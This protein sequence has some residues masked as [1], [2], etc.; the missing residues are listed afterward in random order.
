MFPP[1]AAPLLHETKQARKSRVAQGPGSQGGPVLDEAHPILRYPVEH[2]LYPAL[3]HVR[4]Q[5]LYK[6]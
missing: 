6:S 2:S 4:T 3:R 1:R 5:K